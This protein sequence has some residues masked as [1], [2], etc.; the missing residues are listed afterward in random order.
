VTTDEIVTYELRR[1]K[2]EFLFIGY[3][4]PLSGDFGPLLESRWIDLIPGYPDG[5]AWYR[6]LSGDQQ[7][8]P[9]LLRH[10]VGPPSP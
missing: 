2:D 10:V 4:I 7:V 8:L 5:Y 6:T 1:T 9:A 3:Q